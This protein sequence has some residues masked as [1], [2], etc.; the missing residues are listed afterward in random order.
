MIGYASS[1][2]RIYQNGKGVTG[3]SSQAVHWFVKAAEQG[4][5]NAQ[6]ELG[7]MFHNGE[8][9][10]QDETK[11]FTWYGRAAELG[12]IAAQ[13]SFGLSFRDGQGVPRNNVE[14]YVWLDLAARRSLSD[15]DRTTCANARDT[16]LKTMTTD[17]IAEGQKRV[18]WWLE[19][20]QRRQR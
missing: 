17:Q 10:T 9:V 2:D 7:V 1:T 15:S 18:Q 11:A 19:G 4:E 5:A 6:Y 13:F 3:N 8:R 16:L 14:A 20:F 12:H